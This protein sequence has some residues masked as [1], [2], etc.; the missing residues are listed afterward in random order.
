[1]GLVQIAFWF[2]QMVQIYIMSEKLQNIIDE[3]VNNMTVYTGS[4]VNVK[5]ND[6]FIKELLIVII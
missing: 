3:A 4:D 1:M 6:N 5:T 2:L